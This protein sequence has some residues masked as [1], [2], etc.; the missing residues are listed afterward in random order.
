[1][2]TK[3]VKKKRTSV[4]LAAWIAIVL[5]FIAEVFGCVWLRI[6]CSSLR[7]EIAR[8]IEER[9]ALA[10]RHK[11][12]QIELARLRSPARIMKIAK[13]RLGMVMPETGQ[14]VVIP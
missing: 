2:V 14:V 10:K 8:G 7:Y 12:L 6:Q 13:G 5:L 4:I 9:S 3:K 11:E 1:M